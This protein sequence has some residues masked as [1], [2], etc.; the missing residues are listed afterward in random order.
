MLSKELPQHKCLYQQGLRQLSRRT[1]TS[2]AR[3]QIDNSVKEKQKLFQV[4]LIL[5]EDLDDICKHVITSI[6]HMIFVTVFQML[7]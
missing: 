1:I 5:F 3:R 4:G 7:M 2:S 6:S